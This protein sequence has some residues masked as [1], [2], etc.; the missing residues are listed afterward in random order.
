MEWH[1]ELPD[2]RNVAI[3]RTGDDWIVDC[4]QSRVRSDKLDVALAQAIRAD[5][6]CAGH[7]H[8]VHYAAWVRGVADRLVES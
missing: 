6:D 3:R 2:G 5:T 4:G 1:S 7:A 8:D